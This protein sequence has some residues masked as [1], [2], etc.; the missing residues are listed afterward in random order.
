MKSQINRREFIKSVGLGAA[1]LTIGACSDVCGDIA[2][3][4]TRG[5]NF[6]IILTD[7]QGYSDVG[8]YGAQG[9][10]TPNLDRMAEEGVR[11]TDFYVAAPSCTPSRA[12]LLTGC[13][14]Q[15][16][17]LPYVLFPSGPEWTKDRTEI[18]INSSEQTIAEL[19]KSRGYATGCFGKW[20]LGH[21]KKFLPTRHGFDEYF[22][23]PY[24]N[25]MRPENNS[26]YP[27]LP[28]VD[29][30]EPAEYDPDQRYLTRR[31]TERAVKF[32]EKNGEK[33]FFVYLAHSMPHIPLYVTENFSGKS[34]QGM[35]GDVI[36]EIDFSVGRIL[37]AL[38]RQG[39]DDNTLVIFTSDN[40]PWLAF[41][42]HGG[43]ARPLRE[44]KG[45]TFE[46][47]MR[48]PCIMRWPGEIPAGSVCSELATTMDILPTFVKLAGAKQPKN[49]IDGKDI[50]PLMLGKAG[51]STPHEAFFYYRGWGLEAVRSGKWKLHFPHE[52]R[53]LA[54]RRG[55]SGGR[56]TEYEQHKIGLELFDLDND[57]GEQ[58]DVSAK[59]PE[60]V[61]RLAA[62][63]DKMREDIGD[64]ARQMTGENRRPAGRT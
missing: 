55:G 25:D 19:L 42:D 41:G 32:I 22:G 4:K 18:G 26:K 8:C 38:K 60:V 36:M 43:S 28:L 50:R 31:Y 11:F 3:S 58:N 40:G 27:P 56:P 54:G 21:H 14:P 9:F 59:Y 12:A 17:S 62:L 52:Y 46:G 35:F 33:P 64:S 29:G 48:E 24:S 2:G 47:G 13:Y 16:V 51:A 1:A 45:T 37:E 15:R 49:R 57:I 6:V 20:H 63:A 5:P 61:K 39:I 53:T 44:G 7:D 23:L 10:E 34:E 30:E